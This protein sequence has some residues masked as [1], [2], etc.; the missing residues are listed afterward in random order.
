MQPDE[1]NDFIR[2]K[3]NLLTP[4][5]TEEILVSRERTGEFKNWMDR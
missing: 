4:P 1:T 2:L 5:D 3:I